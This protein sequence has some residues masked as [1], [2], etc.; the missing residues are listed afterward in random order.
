[1]SNVN[2]T[3]EKRGEVYG[4]FTRGIN[5]EAIVMDTIKGR[6]YSEHGTDMN[7]WD[8]VAISKIV[9]KLSRLAVSPEH[10][11]SWH[12]IAGYA[13]LVEQHLTKENTNA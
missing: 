3:L 5:L 11:D 10:V 12:D 13:T 8:I 4:N 9:M 2:E 7:E 1:M 6:Y